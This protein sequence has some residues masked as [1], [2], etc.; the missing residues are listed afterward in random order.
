MF[1]R[2][3]RKYLLLMKTEKNTNRDS[4]F[5]YPRKKSEKNCIL[6]RQNKIRYRFLRTRMSPAHLWEHHSPNF[7]NYTA[8]IVSFWP[9]V[10]SCSSSSN[11]KMCFPIIWLWLNNVRTWEVSWES[12]NFSLTNFTIW[13]F[14]FWIK[15]EK[16]FC[17]EENYSA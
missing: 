10:L 4:A 2:L 12:F 15:G 3:D 7:W 13:E 1:R 8:K 9:P 6:H 14:Y 16:Y 17:P 5:E 11:M